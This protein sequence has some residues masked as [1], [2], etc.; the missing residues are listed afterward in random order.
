MQSEHH[1]EINLARFQV[2]A[3]IFAAARLEN[4]I[5]EAFY[6]ILT[7]LGLSR[8]GAPEPHTSGFWDTRGS[9]RTRRVA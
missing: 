3:A 4:G 6:S 2:N 5:F 1:E 7:T 9:R 8:V